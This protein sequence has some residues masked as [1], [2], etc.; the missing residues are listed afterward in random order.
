MKAPAAHAVLIGGFKPDCDRPAGW[1]DQSWQRLLKYGR[2]YVALVARTIQPLSAAQRDFA[3]LFRGEVE[4]E[5]QNQDEYVWDAYQRLLR[6]NDAPTSK[7]SG[8][9][10]KTIKDPSAPA[11]LAS[12][13]DDAV[14][15]VRRR[16][17]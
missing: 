2:W 7:P 17:R 9:S 14:Y 3:A 13:D 6:Y 10:L 4:R 1:D 12:G 15:F 8:L 5:P 16:R 11:R